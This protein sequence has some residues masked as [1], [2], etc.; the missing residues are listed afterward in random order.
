MVQPESAMRVE[1]SKLNLETIEKDNQI[2]LL[3]EQIESL[4][5]MKP[6]VDEMTKENKRLV[7]ALAN[8]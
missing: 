3:K 6:I 4:E 5:K 1:N 7:N 2:L 8:E